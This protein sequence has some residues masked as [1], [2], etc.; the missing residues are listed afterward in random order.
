MGS[1]VAG[2]LVSPSMSG[3]D[4]PVLVCAYTLLWYPGSTEQCCPVERSSC[5]LPALLEMTSSLCSQYGCLR[6]SSTGIVI[7]HKLCQTFPP[8]PCPTH[9]RPHLSMRWWYIAVSS[10]VEHPSFQGGRLIDS[11]LRLSGPWPRVTKGC[12]NCRG[13]DAPQWTACKLGQELQGR[14]FC[15]RSP[16]L[17]WVISAALESPMLLKGTPIKSLVH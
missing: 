7:S 15:E 9:G 12:N 2:K 16:G 10:K 1:L 5:L 4:S 17:A 14:C 13:E 8:L 6:K 11:V 3:E